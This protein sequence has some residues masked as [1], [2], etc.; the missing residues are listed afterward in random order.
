MSENFIR[1]KELAE[2]LNVNEMY[3]HKFHKQGVFTYVLI[4]GM[5]YIPLAEV[6]AWIKDHTI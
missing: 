5:N 3:I 1:P 2:W 4:D 6:G